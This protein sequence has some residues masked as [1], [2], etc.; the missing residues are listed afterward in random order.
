M[1]LAVE[2]YSVSPLAI[3]LTNQ[4]FVNQPGQLLVRRYASC[5]NAL[6]AAVYAAARRTAA[7]RE[8][9]ANDN[10]LEC[11]PAEFDGPISRGRLARFSSAGLAGGGLR[12]VDRFI[13]SLT[14]QSP[15]K[16]S[17]PTCTSEMQTFIGRHTDKSFDW[18]A[19]PGSRGFP[20]SS[21][22]MRASSD[23]HDF[24]NNARNIG[25][26]HAGLRQRRGSGLSARRGG[27][28]G[29]LAAG[30]HPVVQIQ[31]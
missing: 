31:Q 19:F 29:G 21:G 5:R 3:M 28:C 27:G 22:I 4:G 8:A 9:G 13:R 24:D 23:E 2:S 7:A 15:Y 12:L 26:A 18:D 25:K 11:F 17:R 10:R 30:A 6:Q 14:C 20:E 1:F 16:P